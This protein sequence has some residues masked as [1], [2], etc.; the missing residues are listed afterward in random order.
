MRIGD[1]VTY[2]DARGKRHAASVTALAGTGKSGAKMLDLSFDGGTAT[3]VPHSG[4]IG[5]GSAGCWHLASETAQ[6]PERRAPVDKQPIALSLAE[7][8][9]TLPLSER[10]GPEADEDE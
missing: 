10:R 3:N 2:E 1:R 7:E 4:D 9:G 5:D 8:A 6:P